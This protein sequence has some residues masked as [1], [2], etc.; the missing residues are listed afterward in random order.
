MED[1]S[2][3]F[4]L[5]KLQRI[6][7]AGF[8]FIIPPRCLGCGSIGK[9]WC[10]G[11]DQK[12]IVPQ[13]MSCPTCGTPRLFKECP[14]CVRG[15]VGLK[16]RSIAAYRPPLSDALISFKYRP[17]LA[18]AEVLAGW[19]ASK[20]SE[21]AWK[22]DLVVPVPLSQVRLRQRGY[23]QVALITKSLSRSSAI[24]HGTSTI[25][26]VRDT[27]SQ[28]GL[29]PRERYVNMDNA[30]AV[31]RDLL[32]DKEVLLIDDLLTTG[33]TM[34]SCAEALLNAGARNVNAIAI[35]RA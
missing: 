30:F 20:L 22:P 19:V 7:R 14:A 1:T 35:A 11:C 24:P 17:D 8:D 21:L 18:F 9:S 28:V 2:T 15:I 33:A 4:S 10:A 31:K 29:A 13:G 34:I 6:L 16:V 12:R 32:L 5:R 3:R 26:R 27:R 25:Q 23:N